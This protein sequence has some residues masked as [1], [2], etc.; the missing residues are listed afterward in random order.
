MQP[1]I[2]P[3]PSGHAFD[4]ALSERYSL[5]ASR[6]PRAPAGCRDGRKLVT[7]LLWAFRLLRLDPPAPTRIGARRRDVI[8]NIIA[9]RR[10]VRRDGPSRG[11]GAALPLSTARAISA[12]STAITRPPTVTPMRV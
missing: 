7:A 12:T 3:T 2:C 8:V 5:F 11:I 10:R 9:R 1:K 4:A 6:S